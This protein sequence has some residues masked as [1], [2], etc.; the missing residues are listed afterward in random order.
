MYFTLMI[1]QIISQSER[2]AVSMLVVGFIVFAMESSCH[3]TVI[4]NNL[5]PNDTFEN[6]NLS[7][8]VLL[9]GTGGTIDQAV[10]FTAPAGNYSWQFDTVEMPVSTVSG[11]DTMSVQLRNNNGGVPGTLIEPMTLTGIPTSSAGTLMTA[12]STTNPV[13]SA[14]Q[15]YWIAAS[16]PSISQLAWH[17][18]P[19]G[20]LGHAQK[21]STFNWG[22][23]PIDSTP[24]MR[25]NADAL[26]PP[27]VLANH[28]FE[29]PELISGGPPTTFADWAGDQGSVS[30]ATLG[31]TPHQGNSML[32]FEGTAANGPSAASIGSEVWQLVDLSPWA[33][34]IAA[35]ILQ[36]D[37][38]YY[39]N[40]VAG[41]SETDTRFSA[42]LQ[43]QSG[44]PNA[45]PASLTTPLGVTDV[46]LFSDALPSSWELISTTMVVPAGTTYIAARAAAIENIVNDAANEFDGH[47]ADS[48]CIRISLIPEPSSM[49]LAVAAVLGLVVRRRTGLFA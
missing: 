17:D 30:P 10:S 29:I 16:A 14:G 27:C 11:V 33:T 21:I 49:A 37:F 42:R 9:N 25:I 12:T 6:V 45:F 40:R 46:S 22:I 38:E 31:I 20:Q 19:I 28:D 23:D 34:Q 1:R 43:A 4:F 13:L 18:N 26:V 47:F 7:A 35:G 5:G 24:A 3:A 36:V 2:R 8:P 15:T 41:D 39:A 44:T 48:S 32:R